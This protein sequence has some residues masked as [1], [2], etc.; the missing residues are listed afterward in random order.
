MNATVRLRLKSGLGLPWCSSSLLGR[1]ATC[2][3]PK[4]IGALGSLPSSVG[5]GSS[6]REEQRA[7]Y[8]RSGKSM[9]ATVRLRLKSG[10]GLP[11]CSSS[12]LG[13]RATCP[14]MFMFQLCI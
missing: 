13:R 4:S 7:R 5:F 6:V 2:T 9:N 14:L 11:W 12:L 10:L 1:R 8:P 3:S